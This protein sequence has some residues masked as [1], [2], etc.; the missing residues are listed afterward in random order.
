M[1]SLLYNTFLETTDPYSPYSRIISL[2]VAVS[3]V[4]NIILYYIA[5]LG[6][7]YFFHVPKNNTMFLVIIL[8]IM[9]LGYFGRLARTKGIYKSLVSKMDPELAR[10]KASKVI[11]ESYFTWYFLS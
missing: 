5:Y 9:I 4:I 11:R 8:C 7:I 2:D 6:L 1:F 3:I 10:Y